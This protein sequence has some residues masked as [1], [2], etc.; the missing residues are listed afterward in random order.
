MHFEQTNGLNPHFG[1][2][3]APHGPFL[4]QHIFL[5]KSEN[6]TFL[7]LLQNNLMQKSEKTNGWKYVK[8]CCR[9]TDGR[10]DGARLLKTRASPKK[11]IWVQDQ[12]AFT[13]ELYL[14]Q[15]PNHI[16]I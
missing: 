9:L 1:P 16:L 12:I 5:Q 2:F 7:G 15:G 10:T 6:V 13:Y 4:G 14:G 11:C 3:L 8:F